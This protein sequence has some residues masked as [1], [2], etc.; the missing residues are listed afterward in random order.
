MMAVNHDQ[1]KIA[2]SLD[3]NSIGKAFRKPTFSELNINPSLFII[4]NR[5]LICIIT[6]YRQNSNKDYW[7]PSIPLVLRIRMADNP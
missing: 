5:T 7:E 4:K 1:M 2:S 3:L 6:Y